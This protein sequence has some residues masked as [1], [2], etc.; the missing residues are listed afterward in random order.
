M[1][2]RATTRTRIAAPLAVILAALALVAG[3]TVHAT[4]AD[5]RPGPLP[6]WTTRPCAYEDSNNCRW[7]ATTAGNG[8][9]HSFIVRRLP[10]TRLV[11]VF[12]TA[13][14]YA[15]RHDHCTRH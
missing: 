6:T 13:P 5:T 4:A 9:G 10:G 15:A 1:T 3:L 11:C 12:Y 2:V 7:D 14:R 8:A